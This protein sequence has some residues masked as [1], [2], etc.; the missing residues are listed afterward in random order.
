MCL[1]RLVATLFVWMIFCASNVY[2]QQKELPKTKI[3]FL[4]SAFYTPETRLGFGGLVYTY[5]KMCKKDTIVRK[6]NTQT[7]LS[8]SINQQ[9]SV[10]T[11]YQIWVYKNKFY[12]TGVIDYSKFPQFFYGIGNAT[13]E[14]DK[15]MVS[16]DLFRL[17]F[18]NL[19]QVKKRLYLGFSLNHQQ[20]YNQDIKLVS[21]MAGMEIYGN[22]GYTATGIGPMLMIDDRDNPLNPAK[23]SYLEVSVVDY[24]NLIMNQNSFVNFTLDAR[25]Y[26]TFFHKLI[27]N[28]NLYLA[29]NNG[30]VPYRML[31]EIGGTRFMR[32]YYRGRFRD[33]NAVVLQH[34]VRMPV[35][36]ILG[37]A[38][39]GGIGEVA[40]DIAQLRSNTIHY[41]YG[42]GARIR[43]N[44]KE[45]TNIRIDYGFTKDSQGLYVVFA[46]AF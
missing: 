14:D 33:N 41:H 12:F 44:K 11:D 7:Y 43:I 19:I 8:Y 16:F 18:K 2:C 17:N 22:M 24:Q 37:L 25:K 31:P 13:D 40:N 45:N 15:V 42:L 32:G 10:E 21:G 20:V 39:F 29:Y 9:Y 23:G 35:Y 6:S 36:K 34:E 26:I 38:L 1:F 5:F 3:G 46:E 28:G 27:W 30:Q 4:P